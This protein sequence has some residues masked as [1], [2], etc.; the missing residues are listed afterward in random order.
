MRRMVRTPAPLHFRTLRKL[1]T[2]KRRLAHDDGYD[3]PRSERQPGN[4]SD[5]PRESEQIGNDSGGER[6]NGVA[7]VA[8]EAID[9]EGASPPGGMRRIRDGGNQARIHHRRPNPEK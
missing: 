7:K 2:C 1:R 8:P 3:D 4:C 9:A 6:A 5:G